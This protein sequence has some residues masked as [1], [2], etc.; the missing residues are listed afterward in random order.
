MAVQENLKPNYVSITRLVE[1]QPRLY[2]ISQ[3][4]D[5]GS[6]Q[7]LADDG[8]GQMVWASPGAPTTADFLVKTANTGLS[9]ER[10]VTDTSTVTW[11]WATAGQA[12]AN[13]NVTYKVLQSDVSKTNNTFS[14]CTD[15]SVTLTASH[16]YQIVWQF[17]VATGGVVGGIWDFNG[18]TAT[19][20][21]LL[22]AAIVMSLE[23]SGLASTYEF[24]SLA[25]TMA[26][27]LA[28]ESTTVNG[29]L[30]IQVNAGGTFIPRFAQ[31][32]TNATPTVFEK[33]S[34][35]TVAD[36]TP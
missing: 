28:G 7:V 35:M 23:G 13:T 4:A 14:N 32:A 17:M 9:A 34:W 1:G 29:S 16:W 25:S 10:V 18:G 30:V 26:S 36:I 20:T 6:Q 5:P 33:Y 15:L 3:L 11:N 19:A 12:K 8:S 21:G 27:P 2:Q 31:D 24:T 22:G